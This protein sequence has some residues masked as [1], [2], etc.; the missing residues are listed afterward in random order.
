MQPLPT[1][2][3]APVGRRRASAPAGPR[4]CPRPRRRTGSPRPARCWRVRTTLYRSVRRSLAAAAGHARLPAVGLGDR[5]AAVAGGRG[6][7]PGRPRGHLADAGG[8]ATTSS[9]AR[10]ASTRR[11]CRRRRA[12]RPTV[13]VLSPT[14][15][16]GVTV[17]LAND[18]SVDEPHA[19]V[20]FTLADQADGRDGDPG[21]VGALALGASVDAAPATFAVK[22]GDR[23]RAHGRR[24][25]AAGPDRDGRHRA[26]A[27]H[28][29]SP[30]PPEPRPWRRRRPRVDRT[31]MRGHRIG[32]HRNQELEGSSRGR[33][34]HDHRQSQ[35]RVHRDPAS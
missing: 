11:R 27:G 5:P 21:R 6:G 26:P 30:R 4:C 2:A 9:C 28:C 24:R 33:E 7:D 18:G 22:P 19:S 15:R 14:S 8:D 10:S 29:R 3:G 20:R 35:W 17:V 12:R 34:H 25:P 1:P 16:I 23:L 32:T 31:R 13:S